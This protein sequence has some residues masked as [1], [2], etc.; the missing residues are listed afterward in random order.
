M[1][2]LHDDILPAGSLERAAHE[3]ARQQGLMLTGRY[4]PRASLAHGLDLGMR[5]LICLTLL[6]A[7]CSDGTEEFKQTLRARG[8]PFHSGPRAGD[9]AA[10]FI[11]LRGKGYGMT[12]AELAEYIKLN[13]ELHPETA[14]GGD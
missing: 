7:G 13:Q 4:L 9:D 8:V 1:C 12:D 10:R 3:I 5:Y 11:T 14:A 2:Q 6:A